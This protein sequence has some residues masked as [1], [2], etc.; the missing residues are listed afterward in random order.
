MKHVK[1]VINNINPEA[2]KFFD[3]MAKERSRI[4]AKWKFKIIKQFK[5]NK[6]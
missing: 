2:K 6:I 3:A 1:I 5:L 4:D